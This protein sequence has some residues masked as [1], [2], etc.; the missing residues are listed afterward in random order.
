MVQGVLVVYRTAYGNDAAW[1]RMLD[2]LH[3]PVDSLQYEP[4]PDPEL[5]PRHRLE[6]M[7]DQSQFEG[8][9]ADALREKFSAGWWTSAAS[10]VKKTNVPLWRDSTP[11]RQAETVAS[12]VGLA[13]T[14]F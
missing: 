9:T 4:A 1:N 2:V 7:N 6:I 5:Y 10:T 8:V 11:I 3:G 12:W 14:S 13:T